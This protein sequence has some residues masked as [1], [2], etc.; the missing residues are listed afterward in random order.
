MIRQLYQTFI[1]SQRVA[2]RQLGHGFWNDDPAVFDQCSGLPVLE[3]V[4]A[5]CLGVCCETWIVREADMVVVVGEEEAQG[6]NRRETTMSRVAGVEIGA[7]IATCRRS[8][9][10]ASFQRHGIL[11]IQ[12]GPESGCL[13]KDIQLVYNTGNHKRIDDTYSHMKTA[14]ENEV[15][16]R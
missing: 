14:V 9:R 5:S 2:V 6:R 15:V 7:A 13:I 8:V 3:L 10:D 12:L 1:L 4:V 11:V 16:T